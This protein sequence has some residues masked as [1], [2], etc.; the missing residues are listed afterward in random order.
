MESKVDSIEQDG[1][2]NISYLTQ[3][4][5]AQLDELLTGPLGFTVHQ[6]MELA[7]LSVATAIAET[8]R[9]SEHNRVLVI[10]GPGNNGGGGLV[11]AR[12]LRNFGYN[13]SISYPKP[14]Y[15]NL[16]TQLES[17]SVPFLSVED[18]TL[19]ISESFDILV[20]AT[21]GFSF[22]DDLIQ[23]VV[24]LQSSN[25]KAVIVCVD[26]P[27]GWHI[28]EGD[29]SGKGLKP[30]ML[31][32]LFAPKFCAKTFHG[33][34]HFL[35]GRFIPAAILEKFQLQLPDYPGTSPCVRIGKASTGISSLKDKY[36]EQHVEADPFDQFQKWLEDAMSAG[37]K[38]ATAA[39]VSTATKDGKTSS[40]MVLLR[41]VDRDGFVWN[42][43]YESRKGQD[44][45]E[46]P[47][48]ALLFCWSGL[49]REA[50][51]EGTVQKISEQESEHYFYSRPIE[52]QIAALVSKQSTVI[53]NRQTL[54][55][56]YKDLE[57][58]YYDGIVIP[59]PKSAGGYRLR[60]KMFEFLQGQESQ[61]HYRLQY[62]AQDIDGKKEWKIDQSTCDK[63]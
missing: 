10:C 15:N 17:L 39:A 6:L 60:P 9:S 12:H 13:I 36:F 26:I 8:Y 14:L 50:R 37:L 18:L 21:F 31:V 45:S 58:K 61:L 29:L 25:Q 46:N 27:S 56:E 1:V 62:T 4:Q 52:S 32:S 41:S 44:I 28:E 42:S 59:K 22:L 24:A 55:N 3:V 57:T 38:R 51:V 16:V 48:A 53:P 54:H 30:H 49:N 33:P 2:E 40:R 47:H 19:D 35:G 11:S 63:C 23:R 34:H 20:D 7:A 5:A 43:N